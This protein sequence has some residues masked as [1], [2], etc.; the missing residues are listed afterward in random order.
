MEAQFGGEFAKALSMDKDGVTASL[1]FCLGRVA[2]ECSETGWDPDVRDDM[3][4]MLN[5]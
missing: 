5:R 4:M 3:E 1:L 2:R